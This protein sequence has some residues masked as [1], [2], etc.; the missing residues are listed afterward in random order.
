[1][2]NAVIHERCKREIVTLARDRRP[3]SKNP[4]IP[5]EFQGLNRLQSHGHKSTLM[6][7]AEE[8]RAAALLQQQFTPCYRCQQCEL[9]S[10]SSNWVRVRVMNASIDSYVAAASSWDV[11]RI[12]PRPL[13]QML[14]PSSLARRKGIATLWMWNCAASGRHF[15][16]MI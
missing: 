12:V 6:R 15:T 3:I 10:V 13:G 2:Y 7:L 16:V 8:I 11:A 4:G 5:A 14:L 1:M 9:T